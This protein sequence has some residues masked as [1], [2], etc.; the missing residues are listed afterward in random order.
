VA[1]V[2]AQQLDLPPS[3]LQFRPDASSPVDIRVIL[4]ADYDPC[5]AQ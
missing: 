1:E 4:G 2:V 3:A 5:A